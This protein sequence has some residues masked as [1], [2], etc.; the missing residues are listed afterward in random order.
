[1]EKESM[2]SYCI[3]K[4]PNVAKKLLTASEFMIIV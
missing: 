3:L 4:N 1:M 2:S